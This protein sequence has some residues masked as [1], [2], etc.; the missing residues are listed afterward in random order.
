M[1]QPEQCP[2]LLEACQGRLCSFSFDVHQ[3]D[4]LSS[5][6][7]EPVLYFITHQQ[8]LRHGPWSTK[9]VHSSYSSGGQS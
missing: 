3:A 2:V 1:N 9:F 6:L 7:R 8:Q 5:A 4:I